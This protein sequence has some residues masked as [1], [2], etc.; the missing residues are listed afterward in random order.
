MTTLHAASAILEVM[1]GLS[2]SGGGQP[3]PRS[4]KPIERY[5]VTGCEP[6]PD[7]TCPPGYHKQAVGPP[8]PRM[9]APTILMCVP[10]KPEPKE[11]KEKPSGPEKGFR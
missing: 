7:Q 4:C 5:G 3:S 8:D 9:K 10:D 2:S 11:Q 1:I 6:L